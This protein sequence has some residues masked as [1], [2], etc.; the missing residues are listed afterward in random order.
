MIKEGNVLI[1]GMTYIRVGVYMNTLGPQQYHHYGFHLN[2]Y[3][4]L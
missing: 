3:I 4:M 2:E 1:W